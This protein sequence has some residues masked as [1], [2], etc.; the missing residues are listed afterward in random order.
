[1]TRTKAPPPG[2]KHH[3]PA[4]ARVRRAQPSDLAAI[5]QLEVASFQDY[6]RASPASLRRSITSGH[7]SFWVIDAP[8]PP[9]TGPLAALLVLW[10]FPKTWRV[11]D[12]ATHPDA[13]GHGFGREL[14]QHAESLARKAGATVMSLEAEEQD[15]RLVAWYESQGYDVVDRLPHFYHNGCSAVRMRKAL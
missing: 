12:I 9:K 6:R 4:K 14:M 11:Y 3:R 13:R 15:K 8:E 5:L 7:Q 1:M 10:H 2:H